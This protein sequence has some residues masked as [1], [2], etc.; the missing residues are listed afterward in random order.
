M[1]KVEP[2]ELF[3]G[4]IGVELERG[5]NSIV[6]TYRPPFFRFSAI[7]SAVMLLL[8]AYITLRTEQEA[9]RRRKVRMA[10]R[11]VELNLSRAGSERESETANAVTERK[12]EPS[13]EE[14]N[15][16]AHDNRSSETL[17]LPHFLQNNE[18]IDE[19]V[20]LTDDFGDVE[21]EQGDENTTGESNNTREEPK[22]DNQSD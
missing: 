14:D 22:D 1:E 9:A 13:K 3:D 7:F 6:M 19:S 2:V 16:A 17:P 5:A 15:A 10:F 20:L 11:A 4:L 21:T 12:S 8:G 18:S